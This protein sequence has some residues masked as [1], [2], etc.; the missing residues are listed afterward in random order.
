MIE[1]IVSTS[2]QANNV[3]ITCINYILQLAKHLTVQ[4]SEAK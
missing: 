2:K 1:Y 4:E 3:Y